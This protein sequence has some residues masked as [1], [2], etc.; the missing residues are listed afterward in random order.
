MDTKCT[1]RVCGREAIVEFIE[2][3]SRGWPRCCDQLMMIKETTADID[4][5]VAQVLAPLN[6]A[7]EETSRK[8]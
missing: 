1:C 6:K 3:V 7:I 5:V 8:Q 2:C 4:Q